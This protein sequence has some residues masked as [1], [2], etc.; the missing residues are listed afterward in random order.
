MK[1]FFR[2]P[3]KLTYK[4]KPIKIRYTKITTN[5]NHKLQENNIQNQRFKLGVKL[6]KCV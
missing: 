4:K 5:V 2:T 6:R 1:V 3:L